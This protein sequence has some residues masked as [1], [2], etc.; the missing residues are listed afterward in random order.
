MLE[1]DYTNKNQLLKSLIK[2]NKVQKSRMPSIQYLNILS[3]TTVFIYLVF[4]IAFNTWIIS[5]QAVL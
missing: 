3:K 4:N 1:K 5:P 2:S